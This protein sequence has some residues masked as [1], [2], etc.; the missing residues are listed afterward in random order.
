MK[1]KI[2][3]NSIHNHCIICFWTSLII[4]LF[5]TGRCARSFKDADLLQGNIARSETEK[6]DFA[7]YFD[8]NSGI[9]KFRNIRARSRFFVALIIRY[10]FNDTLYNYSHSPLMDKFCATQHFSFFA[11]HSWLSHIIVVRWRSIV[12]VQI[13]GNP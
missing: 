4:V 2:D 7:K 8:L 13:E 11:W 12:R 9:C 3:Y 6:N 5:I 1:G 10:A